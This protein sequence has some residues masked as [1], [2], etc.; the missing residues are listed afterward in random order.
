MASSE[1]MKAKARAALLECNT[2]TEAADKAGISRKTLYNYM[3]TD[4]TFAAEYKEAQERLALEEMGTV[5]KDRAEARAVIVEIMNNSELSPVV[6]LKA[7][8]SLY[9]IAATQQARIDT[10]M[11]ANTAHNPFTDML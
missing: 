2:L 1:Q 8:A 6:R 5:A 3:K 7:A 10:I 11:T 9:G 4:P